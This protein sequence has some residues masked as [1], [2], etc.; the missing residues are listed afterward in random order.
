[1]TE[2]SARILLTGASGLAGTAILE[3][4]LQASLRVRILVH[5]TPVDLCDIEIVSGDLLEEEVVRS[6][7][8]GCRAIVHA[9]ALM[10][11][12]PA[13]LERVNVEGTRILCAAAADAGVERLVF[14][15]SASIYRPGEM[16]GADEATAV[17]P[18]D[19]YGRSKV[20]AESVARDLL[21]DKVVILRPGSLY[22]TGPCPIVHTAAQVASAPTLPLFREG[23][24][25]IDL[26][27]IDDLAQAVSLGLDSELPTGIYNVTGPE[28]A[29]FREL[30]DLAA[31]ASGRRMNWIEVADALEID[32]TLRAIAAVPRTLS[33]ERA[34]LQ[35]GYSP[36]RDWRIEIAAALETRA[37][38][39]PDRT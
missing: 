14:L 27:H 36:R 18:A 33:I 4:L 9:A 38:H 29:P 16:I 35:L 17:E 12:P 2:P 20:L 6:A 37:G 22:R 5:R 15:S 25:P 1:M 31:A 11:A 28:P 34:R 10:A 21:G 13:E 30:V 3:T 7:V 8:K 19:G 26:L 32:P 23:R 39:P 24:T